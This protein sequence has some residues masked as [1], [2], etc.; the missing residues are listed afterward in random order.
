MSYRT[1]ART[2]GQRYLRL[3]AAALSRDDD[4]GSQL[5]ERVW[6]RAPTD[7]SAFSFFLGALIQTVHS[8]RQ[9]LLRTETTADRLQDAVTLLRRENEIL[10]TS[11]RY[12]EDPSK[13][14]STERVPGKMAPYVPP[15]R[16]GDEAA[17]AAVVGASGSLPCRNGGGLGRGGDAARPLTRRSSAAPPTP[18]PVAVPRLAVPDTRPSCRPPPSPLQ[19]CGQRSYPPG[20]LQAASSRRR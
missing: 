20:R 13:P 11:L 15:L 7:P 4:D 8:D 17:V 14:G 9:R 18:D 3:L 2:L 10:R 6:K 1:A 19:P 12:R 16:Q 5:L